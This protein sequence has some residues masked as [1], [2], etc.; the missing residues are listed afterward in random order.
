MIRGLYT[1]ASGMA[2]QQHR[3]D[4]LANNMANVDVNGYK[5]DVSVHKAFP[6]LL[7]RR[8]NDDGVWKLPIG[9]GD[10][11][12]VVGRIG[13]GVAQNEVFTIFSQGALK[14]TDNDFDL[15]MEGE[16]FFS[17]STLRGERYTRNGSFVLSDNG[18]LVTKG[19][20]LVMGEDEPIRLK[21]NNFVVDED[22]VIWQN[23]SFAGNDDRLVSRE[24][25][26]WDALERVD[27][28]RVVDFNHTR[29]LRKQG[30]SFWE[31]TETSGPAEV[32]PP[33]GR[34]KVR[35][36]FLE[37]SNVNVVTEMV[38]M[39]EVQRAY[40]ANQKLIQTQDAITGQLLNQVA[41]L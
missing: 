29:Y 14:Q 10:S 30:D 32:V 8:M 16:G 11:A 34:P 12:P 35:Q 33:E 15:A 7:L 9:S 17:V 36:G 27:R 6:G 19:G 26:E 21:K 2:A 13:T 40:E 20:E 31:A 1:G 23:S 5:R 24:E 22:G 4:A 25:N 28:L 38:Q 3:I 39:I 18:Y 41:R 37:G